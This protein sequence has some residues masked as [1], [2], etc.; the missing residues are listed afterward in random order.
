MICLIT[1]WY[2][3][4]KRIVSFRNPNK[5]GVYTEGFQNQAKY[6]TWPQNEIPPLIE[7]FLLVGDF[8]L[9]PS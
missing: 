3:T 4:V 1:K 9:E 7:K 2:N 8:I 6:L 5:S